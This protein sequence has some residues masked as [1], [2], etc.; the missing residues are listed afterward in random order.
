MYS[1]VPKMFTFRVATR[2]QYT[3][4]FLMGTGYK[5][6]IIILVDAAAQTHAKTPAEE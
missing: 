3:V 2:A 5:T 6:I 4:P 1:Y